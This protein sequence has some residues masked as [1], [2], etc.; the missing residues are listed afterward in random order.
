M[1]F[2]GYL[3]FFTYAIIQYVCI[4]PYDIIIFNMFKVK[5]RQVRSKVSLNY[6]AKRRKRLDVVLGYT[7]FITFLSINH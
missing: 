4:D 5:K 1:A 2:P 7:I 6:S 3:K